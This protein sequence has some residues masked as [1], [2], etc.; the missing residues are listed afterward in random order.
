MAKQC[1]SVKR[2]PRKIDGR[3]AKK[4]DKYKERQSRQECRKRLRE[5]G[6]GVIC[7]EGT[8]RCRPKRDGRHKT[9]FGNWCEAARND[10]GKETSHQVNDR[11]NGHDRRSCSPQ[12]SIDSNEK[13]RI[14]R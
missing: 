13:R 10:C 7:G 12:Y 3:S 1:S 8:Q 9:S 14:S 5:Q 2:T 6:R 11:L 4:I